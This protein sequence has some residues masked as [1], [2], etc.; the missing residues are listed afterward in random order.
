MDFDK[1]RISIDGPFNV[2]VNENQISYYVLY[3][4]QLRPP[5]NRDLVEEYL[6]AEQENNGLR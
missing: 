4:R 5:E 2:W 6:S 3:A 1:Y